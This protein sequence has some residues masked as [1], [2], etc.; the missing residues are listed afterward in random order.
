[1]TITPH[2]FELFLKC[3]TKCWL[4][5]AGEPTAGDAYAEWLQSQNESYRADAATRLMASQ[6]ADDAAPP[7]CSSRREE[8]HYSSENLKA[9]K[10]RVA[11]DVLVQTE[12]R[13]SRGN[14]AQTSSP[15]SSPRESQRN[16]QS[17][18]TSAAT[19]I[20]SRLHAI[21][22]IPSE[23]RGKAAQFVPIR[24]IFRNK[25]TKDDKLLLAFDALVLSEVLGREV[26]LGK[27]TH[28]DDHAT[29]KVKTSA[30][31]G[32]VR[33]RIEKIAL[34]LANPTPP[35]LVLNRHCAECEFQ[36]RCRKIAVEKDDLSLLARMSAKERQQLR[37]KGIFTVT[38]LSYTF[39]PRRRPKRQ[40]DKREKYHHSL[41]ALAIREKKIHIVGS[42]ELKIE[43]TPVYLDV[44]GLPDR[45]FYYLIGLRIGHG[46]FAVQHS[47]WADTFADEGKIWREFLAILE[48]IEKPVLIHY[49]SYETTFSK[50]LAERHG[51]PQAESVAA[52]AIA[53]ALNL[54]LV[55]FARIYFPTFSN[56]L[57]EIAGWLEFKWSEADAS[58]AVSIAWRLE[59]EQSR[60]SIWV[61]RLFTY[62][63]EDC[64]A[65]ARLNERFGELVA[66]SGKANCSSEV[67]HAD[68]LPRNFPSTFKTNQFQFAEFEQINQAAYWDYQREKVL[69]KSSERLKRIARK[70]ATKRRLKPRVNKIVDW[71]RP[72]ICPKC[73]GLKIYKHQTAMKTVIDVRFG[74]ASVKKWATKYRFHYFRCPKCRAVFY[75]SERVWNDQK[76][77]P[78]LRA[79]CVYQNIEL[80]L[81]QRQVAAFLNLVLGF[82]L[83]PT[84]VNQFK[85]TAAA[86]YQA[87]HEAMLQ[88]IIGGHLVHADETKVNLHAQDG[89]VWVFTN[90]EEAVYLYSPTREGGLVQQVLKDFNGVLVSDFYA[91][92]DSLNCAQQK[93]LIHL[94]RDLNE[95]VFKEPFN[96]EFKELVGEVAALLKPMI[97]TIDRFGLK[98]R[99][100]RKHKTEVDRFFE[101]LSRQEYQSETA[102]KCKQRL[103]KNDKTL[104]TFLDH[105]DV[106]WNNNNAEHAV[107][108]FALLRR[109]FDG[110]TTEKG[111][112]EYLILLSVCQ[113]CK[114][115]GLDFL[116]FLRSGEKDIHA[117]AES[118][119]RRRRRT[120]LSPATELPANAIPDGGGQS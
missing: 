120:Q 97:E 93:C 45:D 21:E 16:D 57:K 94:I 92:Y 20:K 116:D 90:L 2:L 79:F 55:M 103:E 54:V 101:W 31:A 84:M 110:L 95:D 75:N 51:G 30:L 53:S 109:D 78:N 36:A 4:R 22:R 105:D 64:V 56:G 5:A 8:A 73:G 27:I 13:S 26:R 111:I 86:F 117:F 35:D 70:I 72:T 12:F 99:F 77:G 40:R 28:G 91:A 19:I 37:S 96:T 52:K 65:L 41:K 108:A 18:L 61:Q 39:R 24:F 49:G 76:F 82:R 6:P 71:P 9:A 63:T 44:E 47:L 119:R 106:P 58:G 48:T 11:P 118:R 83:S 69:V 33:K 66:K 38:Q 80:R 7:V 1:M 59:W 50:Q 104:F 112:K 3:Q 14:E 74:S 60:S 81:P 113:T 114:Y 10:W 100:L 29:L 107:K 34:L 88:S 115:M 89:Y 17:L 87:T 98:T 46:D 102:S 67:V 23:G 25:L 68:S 62:N 85:E 42:P 15:P 32:E 43:G